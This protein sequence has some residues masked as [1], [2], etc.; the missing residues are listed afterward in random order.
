MHR[1]LF[2]GTLIALPWLAGAQ[3]DDALAA[4]LRAGACAVLLRHA[5]TEPGV[6]DPPG[7]RLAQ[8]STQRNLSVQGRAQAGRIGQWFKVRGLAPHA[9]QSSAWCRCQDTAELA[10]GRHAVWPA[11]NSFFDAA[12][13]KDAQTA[14]LRAALASIPPG[15]FEVWVTHQ[16]N[17]TAL[18]GQGMAMGEALLVDATGNMVGRSTFD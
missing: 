9:V 14:Q 13:G 11:L 5:Q 6:G 4:R 16:V 17:M 2:T 8:C 1:R 7:F 12:G 15:R 3:T 18:T 10:F